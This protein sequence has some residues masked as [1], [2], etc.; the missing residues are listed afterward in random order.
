M[1]APR[2]GDYAAMT[3]R[4]LPVISEERLEGERAARQAAVLVLRTKYGITWKNFA[5]RYGA[6]A[7]DAVRRD[8]KRFPRDVVINGAETSRLTAKGFR[9]GNAV[10]SEII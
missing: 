1:N 3:L 8:L 6:P 5:K 9:L 7:A 2:L 4:G 10:W